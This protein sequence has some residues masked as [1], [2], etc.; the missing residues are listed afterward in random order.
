MA[1]HDGQEVDRATQRVDEMF[2]NRKGT[3]V[4]EMGIES[5]QDMSAA[6]MLYV[7]GK[8]DAAFT[9]L[10]KVVQREPHSSEAFRRIG[11]VKIMTGERHL[12]VDA[13]HFAALL[14]PM[15]ASLWQ[16]VA[17]LA[18]EDGRYELARNS[19]S[20]IVRIGRTRRKN[21]LTANALKQRA[22]MKMLMEAYYLAVTDLASCLEL[23]PHDPRVQ[24][25]YIISLLK[26][27]K[28]DDALRVSAPFLN[29]A[30]ARCQNR[31][32]RNKKSAV[33][34]QGSNVSAT[35]SAAVT[36]PSSVNFSGQPELSA[37]SSNTASAAAPT[38]PESLRDY[39]SFVQLVAV[40]LIRRKQFPETIALLND[41]SQL[42]TKFDL[43]HVLSPEH[44]LL[45]ATARIAIAGKLGPTKEESAKG[46]P[47]DFFGSDSNWRAILN[48]LLKLGQD[49]PP[50][51]V[52]VVMG[53]VEQVGVGVTWLPS[54]STA[55]VFADQLLNCCCW[56]R[57]WGVVV[58]VLLLALLLLLLLLLR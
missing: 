37:N 24:Q 14:D 23:K 26:S 51:T 4:E 5:Q 57:R 3:R 10:Q 48:P 42:A 11:S 34:S 58:V 33:K 40:C 32:G 27:D 39:A 50:E 30:R 13:M 7:D 9:M 43:P 2:A 22:R 49:A 18:E 25:W 46:K 53:F 35:A 54:S 19:Y 15:H 56:R 36:T 31:L 8:Y 29:R 12:A 38:V 28:T 55:S 41:L 20:R 6:T 47:K 1:Q 17:D 52:T 21:D 16:T 44:R 45:R